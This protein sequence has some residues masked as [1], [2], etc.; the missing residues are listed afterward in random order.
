MAKDGQALPLERGRQRA[1]LAYLVLHANEV[2]GQDR[3]VDA[4]WGE[5]PP[6]TALTALHGYVSRLRRLVGTDRLETRPPGYV[7]HV[8]RD[9]L[10]L[11]RCHDL[12]AQERYAEALA[13][14]RGAPLDDLAFEE[15]ARS[16]IARLEELRLGALERRFD[17]ELADGRH[18]ELVGEL[19]QLA[20]EHPLRE[21]LHA[22]LMLS[23]YRS[24]RQADALEAYSRAREALVDGLGIEPGSELRELQAAILAQD[25]GLAA[26]A[27]AGPRSDGALPLSRAV[28]REAGQG[29]FVGRD[30]V[31]KRLRERWAL[32]V[33]SERQFVLLAGE[34]GIGKTRLAAEL[35]R[36]L[37]AAGAT[38]LYGRSDVES[39]VPYQPFITGFGHYLAGPQAVALPPELAPE[40]RELARFVPALR[41]HL[42]AAEDSALPDEPQTRR[43]RLHAA[44]TRV[45]AAAAR[46]RPVLLALDDLHWA[47]TATA[48]LLS[49]MLSDPEPA[50]LLV[51]GMIRETGES[52]VEALAELL[53]RLRREPSFERVVLH[54]LDVGETGALAGPR[55]S[56]E[57][58]HLLHVRTDGNP[59]FIHETLR[60]LG[61]AADRENAL[62]SSAVPEGVSET[63][64]RRLTRLGGVAE[65]AL[66]VAAVAGREFDFELVAALLDDPAEAVVS[67]LEDAVAAGL[68]RE[69]D[70][71]PGRFVFAHAL[72]RDALYERQSALRR[73]RTHQRIAEELAASG[74]KPAAIAHHF[75]LA[76]SAEAQ[77]YAIAAAHE[78]AAALAYEEAAEHYRRAL[79]A[80]DGRDE[81]AH[82]Q[83]LLDLAGAERAAGDHAARGTYAR[84]AS[85]ARAAGLTEQ[86]AQAALGFPHPIPVAAG[87]DREAVALLEEAIDALGQGDS[88]LAVKL[89]ARLANVLHFYGAEER[90]EA[91]SGAALA[92]ARRLGDPEALVVALESRHTAHWH[93][94]HLDERLA[95]GQ[96]M[97]ALARRIGAPEIEALAQFRRTHSLI[98]AG[99]IDAARAAHRAWATLAAAQ[100]EPI[101]QHAAACF[102]V[103]WV[104]M[105][106][107]SADAWALAEHALELGRRAHALSADLEHAAQRLVLLHHEGRLADVVDELELAVAATPQLGIYRAA[108]CIARLQGGRRAAGVA[109]F[110]ALAAD[111]FGTLPRDQLWFAFVCVLAEA[112][113]LIGDAARARVLYRLLLPYRDRFVQVGMAACWGS[114]EHFLG[115]LAEAGGDADAAATH[116]AAA[117]ERNEAH[118]LDHAAALARR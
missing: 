23:L 87:L 78:A 101:L 45:L 2:V 66:A 79:A 70:E 93:I 13:L 103:V 91:L 100:R 49:H 34:P 60:S 112:C 105:E 71:D 75:F 67:G 50:R 33:G 18:A 73:V 31:L 32:A 54:G 72:V 53:A 48:L 104:L 65:R 85:I 99:E 27:R 113:A 90:T 28:A 10:D 83:L 36:E 3:L 52:H 94:E 7:L 29:P 108:L 15:F 38:V 1:L 89:R 92:M 76:R 64:A 111:D 21:K 20:S 19:H 9:E 116:F 74:A 118:G 102:E 30:A 69:V 109:E 11:Y 24:G 58:A 84:A 86:L 42:P 47:D 97:L 12:L 63:I 96:E 8:A 37:H 44:V 80:L 55:A 68:V 43:Y 62:A 5:S 41:P 107:R 114:A 25:P 110:E 57:F 59:L 26:P 117:V 98:E 81:R 35:G 39:L 6:P 95:L 4:L 115:L 77:R 61:E 46:E 17:R 16:E 22:R 106:D 82:C 40:L 14:W 88:P 56:D 51:L